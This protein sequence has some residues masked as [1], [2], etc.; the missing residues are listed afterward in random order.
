MRTNRLQ[1][2][3]QILPMNR[4]TRLG[5]EAA[6]ILRRIVML[7][8]LSVFP[9]APYAVAA[10]AALTG[11]AEPSLL[12]EG[13]EVPEETSIDPSTDCTPYPSDRILSEVTIEYVEGTVPDPREVEQI[14]RILVL[15]PENITQGLERIVI[16]E[17]QACAFCGGEEETYG[18]THLAENEIF[19]CRTRELNGETGA[20]FAGF[21]RGDYSQ[22]EFILGHEIGH[23]FDYKAHGVSGRYAAFLLSEYP[24]LEEFDVNIRE[25]FANDFSRY[26][27][28]RD[29]IE[30][31]ASDDQV[32]WSD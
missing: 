16:E 9:L 6:R 14:E 7:A 22:L 27:W 32:R 2:S 31:H 13:V 8:V 23:W 1:G 3:E 10:A 17:N 29:Y 21:Q 19:L 18:A 24:G 4:F 15:F 30:L 28:H 25:L 5:Q 11:C 20:V 26:F 12:E